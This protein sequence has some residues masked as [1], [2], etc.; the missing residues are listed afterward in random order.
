MPGPVRIR[1]ENAN[2]RPRLG[3]VGTGKVYGKRFQIQLQEETKIV[4]NNPAPVATVILPEGKAPES[5]A[6]REKPQQET[7]T[8]TNNCTHAH[9]HTQIATN[10]IVVP[11]LSKVAQHSCIPRS[12]DWKPPEEKEKSG[13][14]R[15]SCNKKQ[16][17]RDLPPFGGASTT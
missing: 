17:K 11:D 2:P 13:E 15:E 4:L 16:K 7:E 1:A 5:S 8:H 3:P 14:L 9:T 12:K 10:Q 6:G